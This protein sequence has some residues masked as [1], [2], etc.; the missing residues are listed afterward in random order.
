MTAK[1]ARM[2]VKSL[3][4]T[5]ITS[6]ITLFV[7]CP[8]A[9]D[10]KAAPFEEY[11]EYSGIK[12]LKVDASFF[13][14]EVSGSNGDT[15]E[16][17]IIVP[18]NFIK[19]NYVEVLHFKKESVLE[20]LVKRNTDRIPLTAEDKIIKISVPPDIEVD[21]ST[22][23]GSIE[24]E[25]IETD[26]IRLKSSSGEINIKNCTGSLNVSSSSGHQSIK[27]LT[28]DISADTSSGRQFYEG[29][30]GNIAA[31]S[32]SGDI[33]ING[34]SGTLDLKASSGDLRGQ[35]V[36]LDGDS[37]FSTSSGRIDFDFKNDLNEFTFDLSSSS[38]RLS[39]GQS[40]VKGE[41][42]IGNG[43]ITI[44]GNSSSGDQSYR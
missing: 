7:F 39:V 25:T 3:N 28:G 21:L 19:R 40:K 43:K 38:G 2:L 1:T 33:T 16:G 8:I 41:L 35:D 44:I 26:D 34:Q 36:Y 6:F 31:E 42:V 15:V 37:S 18:Q 22:S 11:F 20:I 10:T 30:T 14:V 9:S 24:I 27:E 32:S 5:L 12:K 29:I 13:N 23:S 17:Q 4:L